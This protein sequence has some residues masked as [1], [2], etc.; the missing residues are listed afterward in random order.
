M[1]GP[2]T[3]DPEAVAGAMYFIVGRGTEGGANL[4]RLNKCVGVVERR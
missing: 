1:A 4:D 2:D 3:R